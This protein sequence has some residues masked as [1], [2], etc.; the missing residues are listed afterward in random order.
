MA[1]EPEKQLMLAAV[2]NYEVYF[3]NPP[4]YVDEDLKEYMLNCSRWTHKKLI[5]ENYELQMKLSGAI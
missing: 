5:E 1:S 2:Q 4:A 3:F